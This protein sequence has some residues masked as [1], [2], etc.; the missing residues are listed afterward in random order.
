MKTILGVPPLQNHA[1]RCRDRVGTTALGVAAHKGF[2][3]AMQQLLE[4]GADVEA[5]NLDGATPLDMA[6]FGGSAKAAAI[7]LVFGS[8]ELELES[9]LTAASTSKATAVTAVL[10]AYIDGDEHEL[11]DEADEMHAA[12]V[13][14][15]RE[16]ARE[17]AES[18]AARSRAVLGAKIKFKQTLAIRTSRLSSSDA[19]ADADKASVTSKYE[20]RAAEWQRRAVAAEARVLELASGDAKLLF[21]EWRL[22]AETSEARVAEIEAERR[23]ELT[24]PLKNFAEIAARPLKSKFAEFDVDKD[25]KLSKEEL[26]AVLMRPGGDNTF[27]VAECDALMEDLDLDGDGKLDIHEFCIACAGGLLDA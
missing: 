2:T 16:R 10:Q 14:A 1:D 6:C 23:G 27:S 22:R 20:T 13:P 19:A 7:L 26:F 18:L 17:A 4:N 8:E 5:E 12:S 21:E 3:E 15:L 11:L 25:G 9:A 24:Q